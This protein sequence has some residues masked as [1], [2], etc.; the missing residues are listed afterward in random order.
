M[1]SSLPVVAHFNSVVETV[2]RNQVTIV[3]GETGSGKSTQ[4]PYLLYKKL[5]EVKNE[6]AK[7]AVTQPRRIAAISLASY[8]KSILAEKNEQNLVDYAVRF[9]NKSTKFTRIKYMTDGLL[10]R[11]IILDTK[12]SNYSVIIIDEVHE[13]S[14]TIDLLVAI[15]KLNFFK[16]SNLKL[17]IMSATMEAQLFS[18]FFDYA[19]VINIP[20]RIYNVKVNYLNT[21]SEEYI[22][23]GLNIIVDICLSDDSGDVLFFLPGKEEILVACALLKKMYND[24]IKGL[25]ILPLYSNLSKSEQELVFVETPPNSRK[26]V[27][28]TNIAETSVTIPNI[29][30]VVDSGVERKNVY[31]PMIQGTSLITVQIAKSSANQRKGRAGRVK[32]GVCYRLYSQ[33]FYEHN[34]EEFPTPEICRVETDEIVLILKKLGVS[35]LP[36]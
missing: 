18:K 9:D 33:E 24:K 35:A 30:F 2:L 28:S 8:V 26:V 11:E 34:M 13:R 3:V 5:K 27:L 17:V 10:L 36:S 7:I 29:V 25:I 19:V 12:L 23:N 6:D 16:K 22:S 15:Y 32:D 20:G 1:E 21:V 14:V 4:L 31:C